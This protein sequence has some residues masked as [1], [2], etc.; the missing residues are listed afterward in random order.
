M[1]RKKK[2]KKKCS[3]DKNLK[4]KA[5]RFRVADRRERDPARCFLQ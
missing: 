1:T 2:I 3:G 4:H 5:N